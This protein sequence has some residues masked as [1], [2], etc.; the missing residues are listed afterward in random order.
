MGGGGGA[1]NGTAPT[2]PVAV[3]L[4]VAVAPGTAFFGEGEP[5]AGT[6]QPTPVV[7]VPPAPVVTPGTFVGGGGSNG[8][9]A[10]SRTDSRHSVYVVSAGTAP[11]QGPLPP[12][13]L[14]IVEIGSGGGLHNLAVV[15]DGVILIDMAGLVAEGA[16]P[17]SARRRAR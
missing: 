9:P 16:P 10:T 8:G 5:V 12:P 13:G 6:A 4:P 2:S 7:V 11:P 1:T 14:N 3:I 17:W 15:G